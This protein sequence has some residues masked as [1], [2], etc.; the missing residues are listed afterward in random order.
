MLN[1]IITTI[2]ALML[3]LG[4]AEA[5]AL[6]LSVD[7]PD[8]YGA[9]GS[10]IGWGFLLTNDTAFDLYVTRV[11]A[12]GSLFGSEG[13]SALGKFRDDIAFKTV[14][15]GIIVAPSVNPYV[16]SFPAD[17]LASFDII[18]ALTGT[19]VTG[20]I[21]LNYDLVDSNLELQ[22]TGVLTAQYNGEEAL[23]SV[24]VTDAAVPEPSTCLLLVLGVAGYALKQRLRRKA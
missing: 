3:L 10:R 23:A 13:T 15:A 1:R 9:T 20:K 24:T 14:N 22:E 16:G 21:Y 6:I 8:L 2:L 4:G 18:G 17:G 12:D 5:E 11:Y 7:N 19:S